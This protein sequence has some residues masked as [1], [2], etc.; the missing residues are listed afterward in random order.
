MAISHSITTKCINKILC[1]KAPFKNL[2]K[3]LE[4]VSTHVHGIRKSDH[5]TSH[6]L[7]Y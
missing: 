3:I 7:A 2:E 1:K 6:A 5:V 4:N